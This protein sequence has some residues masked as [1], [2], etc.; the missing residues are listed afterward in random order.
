MKRRRAKIY[1]FKFRRKFFKYIIILLC[2]I[3]LILLYL[4]FLVNPVIYRTTSSKVKTL[5]NRS[6]NIAITSAMN[7]GLSYQDLI[8]IESNEGKISLLQANSV[9]MNALAKLITRTIQENLRDLLD[10]SV[11]IHIGSFTGI[12]ILSGVGPELAI[13]LGNSYGDISCKFSS[14]F[15]SSGINQ[16]QHKIYLN[17]QTCVNV[18]FATRTIQI[19]AGS[20]VLLCENIILGEIPSTYLKSDSLDE[21]MNLIP[22]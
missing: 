12:P 7:L 5:A 10:D 22:L 11:K 3:G 17:I 4:Q 21:M 14:E 18:I 13:D 16:T 2:I 9:R 15:L 19:I 1:A 6:M 8:K 20:D